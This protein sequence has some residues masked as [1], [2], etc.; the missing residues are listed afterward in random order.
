MDFTHTSPW[1]YAVTVADYIRRKERLLHLLIKIC[2][3]EFDAGLIVDERRT[4]YES[5]NIVSIQQNIRIT[6]ALG[7]TYLEECFTSTYCIA[8][9]RL[10]GW[11]NLK[12]TT[13]CQRPSSAT[14]WCGCSA[15]ISIPSAHV[16]AFIISEA[17]YPLLAFSKYSVPNSRCSSCGLLL[18]LPSSDAVNHWR[19]GTSNKRLRNGKYN[20]PIQMDKYIYLDNTT[21]FH[22]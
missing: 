12:I 3:D 1:R 7:Q 21:M 4:K 14:T 17:Y 2:S 6:C 13:V 11:R 8:L 10:H 5:G 20:V 22:R 9:T 16:R 15:I 19:D 18:S